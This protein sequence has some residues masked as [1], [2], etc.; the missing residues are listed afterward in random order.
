MEPLRILDLRDSPWVDGPGRT[1]LET[2]ERVNSDRF[3]IIVGGFYS[4]DP[5]ENVYLREAR[6]RSLEV[7]PIPDAHAYDMRIVKTVAESVRRLDIQVI[8]TH[9]FRSSAAGYFATRQASLPLVT[10]CHGWITNSAKGHIYK[11]LD[12]QLLRRFDTVIT[13]SDKMRK[14]LE[15]RGFR[16]DKLRT[17]RNTLVTEEYVVDKTDSGFRDEL[18]IPKSTKLIANI[19]RL[20]PEKGQD[21]LIDA[22]SV[23]LRDRHDIVLVFVGIGSEEERLKAKAAALGMTERVRFVGYRT[24]MKRIYN[25]VDL[26][27][28]SSLTEGMPN[29]ILEAL[30]METP[31]IATNVGGTSEIVEHGVSGYL[32]EAGVPSQISSAINDFLQRE[33]DHRKMAKRGSQK[34]RAEFD[35]SHRVQLLESVYSSVAKSN[36][37]VSV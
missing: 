14:Y 2:A 34:V 15:S 4:G 31:V 16:D 8:H 21:L 23:V 37:G 5:S 3:T 9:D 29:V 33:Q 11:Q 12:I 18:S 24:D 30:L 20:S 13:V 7:C 25:S 10:T 6:S 22:A 35:S 17:I 28:Q 32:I 19:G 27:V 26:V 1:V 36:R